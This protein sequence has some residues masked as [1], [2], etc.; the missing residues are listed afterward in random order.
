MDMRKEYYQTHKEERAAYYK[1][2]RQENAE[3]VKEQRHQYYLENK[4]YI[5]QSNKAWR[6]NNPEKDK[7]YGKTYRANHKEQ[8]RQKIARY[9]ETKKGRATDLVYKYNSRDIATNRGLCTL[10]KDWIMDNIFNSKCIY[11]GESDWKRLGADRI[12]NSLP[13]TPENCVCA[14]GICNVERENKNMSVSEFIE[15]R[16]SNP[17]GIDRLKIIKSTRTAIK[18]GEQIVLKKVG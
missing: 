6:K 7:E 16:K 15:W 18:V 17:R 11:C 9:R 13:H 10:T 12:D 1:K 2:W 4:E 5:L 3:K 14:C 8:I